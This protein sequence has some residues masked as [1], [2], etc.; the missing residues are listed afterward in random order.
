M[1]QSIETLL[2]TYTNLARGSTK[3][4]H[5]RRAPYRFKLEFPSK[6]FTIHNLM[7]GTEH[8]TR[9][10]T[11]RKRLEKAVDVGE[12]VIVGRA[13][14]NGRGRPSIVFAKPPVAAAVAAKETVAIKPEIEQLKE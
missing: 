4:K 10:I 12:L 11:L 8:K 2:P 14:R 7:K 5:P 1:N 9:Y 13:T 3:T 6:P